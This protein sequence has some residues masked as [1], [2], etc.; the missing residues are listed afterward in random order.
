VPT[1]GK[2]ERGLL[3]VVQLGRELLTTNIALEYTIRKVQENQDGLA[4]NG[5]HELFVCADDVTLLGENK[6]SK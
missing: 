1:E 4:L 2:L 5:T 3:F 6:Y